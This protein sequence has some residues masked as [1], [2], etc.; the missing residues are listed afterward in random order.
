MAF[1]DYGGYCSVHH[2]LCAKCLDFGR[3]EFNSDE[4]ELSHQAKKRFRHHSWLAD[5]YRLP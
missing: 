4:V 3:E 1:P 2:M 5:F